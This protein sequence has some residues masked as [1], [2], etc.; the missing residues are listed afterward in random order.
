MQRGANCSSEILDILILK[1]ELLPRGH[2]HF[3]IRKGCLATDSHSSEFTEA[4]TAKR[5]KKEEE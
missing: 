5:K 2:F 1:P 4:G 3:S